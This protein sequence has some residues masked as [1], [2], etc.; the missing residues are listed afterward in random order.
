MHDHAKAIQDGDYT[1]SDVHEGDCGPVWPDDKLP[2]V[3]LT[4]KDFEGL[5][6]VHEIDRRMRERKP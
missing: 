2:T 1:V 5:A 3:K 4:D 6:R